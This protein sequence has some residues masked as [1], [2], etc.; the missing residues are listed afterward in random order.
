MSQKKKG[1]LRQIVDQYMD[2]TVKKEKP[3]NMSPSQRKRMEQMSN[4]R[5]EYSHEFKRNYTPMKGLQKMASQSSMVNTGYTDKI[6][7]S[8]TISEINKFVDP[9]KLTIISKQSSEMGAYTDEVNTSK[10]VKLQRKLIISGSQRQ[11]N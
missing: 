9:R 5:N 7:N 6:N 4:A 2:G 10:S 3:F 1:N 8:S 11:L